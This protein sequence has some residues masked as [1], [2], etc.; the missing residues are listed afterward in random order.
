MLTK[1][2][3]VNRCLRSIG[4]TRVES[5]VSGLP[6]A[7]D[8]AELIDE[9]TNEVLGLGWSFNTTAVTE[10]A[11]DED[12]KIELPENTARVMPAGRDR[13]RKLRIEHVTDPEEAYV[14]FDVDADTT[15][16]NRPVEVSL[17]KTY[18]FDDLPLELANY[19][20]AR[21]AR[22][23]QENS[24]GSQALDAFTSRREIEAWTRL[25]DYEA[26]TS[27]ANVLR[28]SPTL[29]RMTYR[30]QPIGWR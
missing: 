22:V 12:R 29:A 23:F 14:L 19:I 21:S 15:E 8:A 17:L 1:L 25:L 10:L 9:I 18:D 2:D 4:E 27:G 26:E 16:F 5:L 28:D 7:E 11:P 3:A 13:Y 30:N 6:D 20:A 24:M